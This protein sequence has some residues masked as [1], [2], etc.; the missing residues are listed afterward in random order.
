VVPGVGLSFGEH[1]GTGLPISMEAARLANRGLN[2][3]DLPLSGGPPVSSAHL[4]QFVAE[5]DG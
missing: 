5:T 4:N 2:P 1:R 3:P